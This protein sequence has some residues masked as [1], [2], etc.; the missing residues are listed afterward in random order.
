MHGTSLTYLTREQFCSA[1]E[2]PDGLMRITTAF[3]TMLMG[4]DF[5]TMITDNLG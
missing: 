4:Y 5:P 3:G 1:L 2:N